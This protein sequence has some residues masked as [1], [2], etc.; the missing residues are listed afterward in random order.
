MVSSGT[1]SLWQKMPPRYQLTMRQLPEPDDDASSMVMAGFS[2]RRPK[3]PESPKKSSSETLLQTSS[4]SVVTPRLN[5]MNYNQKY[6]KKLIFP[7]RKSG[8]VDHFKTQ[9]RLNSARVSIAEHPY[10][11]TYNVKTRAKTALHRND[12]KSR[13]ENQLHISSLDTSSSSM[14]SRS[15]TKISDSSIKL[16]TDLTSLSDR[17]TFDGYASSDKYCADKQRRFIVRESDEGTIYIDNGKVVLYNKNK[18]NVTNIMKSS[19][20]EGDFFASIRRKYLNKP[21]YMNNIMQGTN[22]TRVAEDGNV[23]KERINYDKKT[24]N[25]L[26]YYGEDD[27]R[28]SI[29]EVS[30]YTNPQNTQRSAGIR[31]GRILSP[32]Q[33]KINLNEAE[34]AE[35]HAYVFESSHGYNAFFKM[36]SKATLHQR[37]QFYLRTPGFISEQRDKEICRC[38]MC[39]IENQLRMF[40]QIGQPVSV[41]EFHTLIKKQKVSIPVKM[42]CKD[43]TGHVITSGENK[44]K[45]TENKDTQT[46]AQS[47]TQ[48]EQIKSN[49]DQTATEEKV[50][51]Q[52][53]VLTIT[54]PEMKTERE[55][56]MATDTAQST[57]RN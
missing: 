17:S 1:W 43:A 35:Q 18:N 52:P 6:Q 3:T 51:K 45:K 40:A 24:S 38:G 47:K 23:Q 41:A 12:V 34:S 48:P 13:M 57:T 27:D 2:P 15:E 42:E 8:Y 30:R 11:P 54:L 44:Q 22:R 36:N 49:E 10:E 4:G 20:N 50:T 9:Q 21:K 28:L 37:Q 19:T 14:T 16:S 26:N 29:D 5:R 46:Y 55:H 31:S 33:R 7:T 32:S 53:E 25:I 39:Q 56:T